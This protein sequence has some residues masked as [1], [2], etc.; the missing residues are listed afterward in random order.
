MYRVGGGGDRVKVTRT[1]DR[2]RD[3]GWPP[4][5][6]LRSIASKQLRL[7]SHRLSLLVLR[8]RIIRVLLRYYIDPAAGDPHIYN[9]NVEENEVEEALAKPIED[10]VGT[11]GSRVALGQ[12]ETGRYLRHLRAGLATRFQLCH[13]GIRS[14]SVGA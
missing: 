9:H 4:P 7:V 8:S 10:R 3:K 14:W 5:G 2:K 12:T 11:E 13:H 1:G 6:K